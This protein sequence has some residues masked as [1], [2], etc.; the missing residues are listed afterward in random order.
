MTVRE[1]I[2]NSLDKFL[3]KCKNTFTAI[4]NVVDNC[5]STSTT[6]PLSANQGKVLQDQITELNTDLKQGGI[7]FII[8]NDINI[9]TP[10]YADYSNALK[11]FW[12]NGWDSRYLSLTPQPSAA[13]FWLVLHIPAYLGVT[14]PAD[15]MS[16]IKQIWMSLL[17]NA[18]YTRS[19]IFSTGWGDFE[20]K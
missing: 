9:N 6:M 11:I 20:Q 5:A 16:Y 2:I 7:R 3:A 12:V 19:Y 13:D 17:S 4:A 1:Q 15:D 14:N 18:L 10:N 8:P